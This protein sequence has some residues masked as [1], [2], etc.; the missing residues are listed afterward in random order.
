MGVPLVHRAAPA[1]VAQVGG[2]WAHEQDPGDEAVQHGGH[3]QRQHVEQCEVQEVDRHVEVPGHAVAARHHHAVGVHRLIRV[4]Q[5]EPHDAVQ[6]GGDPDASDDPLGARHGADELGL[7][8]VAD[9]DVALDGEGGDGAGGHVDAQ[10]LQVGD[11]QAAAVAVD[12]EGHHIGDVGQAGG[13]QHDEVGH[14]Q[15]DQVAV[16]GSD[17]VLGAQNHQDH[18]DV[19]GDAHAADERGEEDGDDLLLHRLQWHVRQAV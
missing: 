6:R 16:G 11:A 7:D 9:G 4:H 17:H 15:A 3:G 19:A 12:P 8:G 5:E 14:G 1:A 18:H 13:Q 10:V 2:Q